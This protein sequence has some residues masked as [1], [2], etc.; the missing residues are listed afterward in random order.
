MLKLSSV[1]GAGPRCQNLSNMLQFSCKMMDYPWH[2]RLLDVPAGIKVEWK[3]P[4]KRQ[5]CGHGC[6]VWCCRSDVAEDKQ[7][8]NTRRH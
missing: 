2:G 7:G 8:I 5:C 6:L 4:G 1:S 3:K